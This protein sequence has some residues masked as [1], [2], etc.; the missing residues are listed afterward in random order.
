MLQFLVPDIAE[1]L[2]SNS[3]PRNC[4]NAVI[5]GPRNCVNPAIYGP[6]NDG[7]AREILHE[8]M[9][10][11]VLDPTS[12]NLPIRLSLHF[13]SNCLEIPSILL[14]TLLGI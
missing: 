13:F 10:Q 2:Q 9:C 5:F 12:L 6:R 3:G 8:R 1:M 11:N 14:T 7:Y 4:Q